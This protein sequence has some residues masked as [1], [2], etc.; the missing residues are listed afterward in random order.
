VTRPALGLAVAPNPAFLSIAAEVIEDY[1][2]LLE[3]T[4]ETLWSAGCRPGRHYDMFSDVARRSGLPIVG[5]GVGFSLGTR[6]LDERARRWLDALRRDHA[7]LGFAWYSE[8]LGFTEHAAR[9]A[10]LP[11]PLP[12]TEEAVSV[13]AARLRALADVVPDVAFENNVGYFTVDDPLAE[14]AFLAAICDAADCGLV[15]DLHNVHVQCA[16]LGVAA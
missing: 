4:P 8:H 11:L 3:V 13:V 10:A 15:L 9:Q 1:A 14:P 2:E 7:A 6:G 5:H 12:F 16:N